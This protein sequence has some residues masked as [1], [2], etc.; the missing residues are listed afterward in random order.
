MQIARSLILLGAVAFL[1]GCSPDTSVPALQ[2]ATLTGTVRDSASGQPV[3]GVVIS[4]NQVQNSAP[5]GPN[6]VYVV[7][8]LPPGQVTVYT[9]QVPA[10]YTA[11]SAIFNENLIA[12]QT[13]SLDILV[14][15]Q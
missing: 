11:L 8:N 2:Y 7:K 1:A 15:H 14:Q 13:S 3:A 6:G 4:V 9:L 12:N 10:G 5:T